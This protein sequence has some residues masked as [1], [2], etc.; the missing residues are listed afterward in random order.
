MSI[1]HVHKGALISPHVSLGVMPLGARHQFLWALAN[2][3][4]THLMNGALYV[5]RGVG[6]GGAAGRFTGEECGTS[7]MTLAIQ[8]QVH[9]WI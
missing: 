1:G 4:A 7:F 8:L 5:P 3:R 9:T 6:G 2:A